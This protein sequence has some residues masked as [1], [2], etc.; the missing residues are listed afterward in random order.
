MTWRPRDPSLVGLDPAAYSSSL[1]V[2]KLNAAGDGFEPGSLS[3]GDS[4]VTVP[5]DHGATG[6]GT[7][8]DSVAMQAWLDDARPYKFVPANTYLTDYLD[9]PAGVVIFGGGET[10]VIKLRGQTFTTSAQEGGLLTIAGT[11]VT[12]KTGVVVANVKLDGNRAAVTVSGGTALNHEVVDL[13]YAERCVV[14]E[15]WIVNAVE[16][17]IDTDDSHHN[18][19]VGND[20]QGCG[21][22]G[23]HVSIRSTRNRVIGNRVTGTGFAFTGRGGIDQYGEGASDIWARDNLFIGNV[24][25]GNRYGF[26]LQSSGATFIGNQSYENDNADI[27]SGVSDF[28]GGDTIDLSEFPSAGGQPTGK[29]AETD[30]L[31]GWTFVDTPTGP[32]ADAVRDAGRWEVVVDGNPATAVTTEDGT[33]W[34]YG[35]VG[36]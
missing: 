30:G 5:E 11:S 16:S 17:G 10:S 33:D 3:G 6:D 7:T 35:W 27:L 2:P 23:I 19:L 36:S 1:Q 26:K 20:I 13:A 18:L 21:G 12:P 14:R 25:H 32:D 22:Y 34:V 4:A 8:D 28:G 15:C 29:I 31:D 24:S 9:V